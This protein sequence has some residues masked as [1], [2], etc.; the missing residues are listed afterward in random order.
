MAFCLESNGSGETLH[1]ILISLLADKEHAVRMKAASV[2]VLFTKQEADGAAIVPLHRSLQEQMF[3]VLCESIK[4][5][6]A[7]PVS[8]NVLLSVSLIYCCDF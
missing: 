6:Y 4:N 5:A 2:E 8:G 7:L 3:S 1:E